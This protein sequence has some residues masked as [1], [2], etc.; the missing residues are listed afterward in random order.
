VLAR[1]EVLDTVLSF[2]GIGE[3]YYVAAVCRN[4]R[5]RYMQLCAKTAV[6]LKHKF[7]TSQKSVVVTAARLQLALD[8]DLSIDTLLKKELILA[9][10]IAEY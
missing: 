5:G 6:D 2:V 3:Y 4:W 8:Y 9:K 10:A 7:N 1:V